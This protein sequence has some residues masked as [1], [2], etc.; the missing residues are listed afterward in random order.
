MCCRR[1][2]GLSV[3]VRHDWQRN[4]AVSFG[5]VRC[6]VPAAARLGE[7]PVWSVREQVLYWVDITGRRLHRFNPASDSDTFYQL[8]EDIGCIG[9]RGRGGFIA[10]LRSGL[11]LL[12]ADGRKQRCIFVNES[13]QTSRFNDGRCDRAG[14]FWAGTI[15]EPRD[16]PA[17]CLYRVDPDLCVTRV[18]GDI[19]VSNGLAFS[20]D[21]RVMY[22]ADT[23]AH[24]LY[25]YDFTLAT[26]AIGARR[27]VRHF[28][29]KQPE[30]NYGGRPDG[31]AVDSLGRYWS[32]QYEGGRVVCLAA[33]GTELA[34]IA[35]PARRTTM[36]AFGGANLRTLYVTSARDG[37]S[38]EELASHPR[39]G[40]LFAIDLD[41]SGLPE[42]EFGG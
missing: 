8:D 9:P 6:V 7:C 27:I 13:P 19:T 24:V 15:H 2:T 1:G 34:S 26:G 3:T 25:A 22:H 31:A 39:S 38:A 32:A 33:D 17:A 23:P 12:D 42:P 37:A 29:R 36:C 4:V 18:A 11:W 5:A 16:R 28:D 41:F 40:N 30:R 14:R 20:P 10:G 35:L 21:D